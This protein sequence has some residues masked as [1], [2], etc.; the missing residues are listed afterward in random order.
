MTEAEFL[1]LA[2]TLT[3]VELVDGLVVREPAPGGPH[4]DVV[5]KLALALG[6]WAN[7]R[8][9][10][11][12]VGLNPYDIRFAPGRILQPDMFVI[13]GHVDVPTRG[14]LERIPDLCIEVV[15]RRKYDRVTKRGIYAEAGVREYWTVEDRAVHRW[16]GPGLEKCEVVTGMLTCP[17]LPGFELDV[18]SLFG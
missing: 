3:K 2:V 11:A 17:L 13:L 7:A 10:V 9:G 18:A 1:R 12:Y 8:P 15:S 14:P 4:Q 6:G 5:L 16:T